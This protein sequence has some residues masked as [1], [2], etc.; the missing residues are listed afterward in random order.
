VAPPQRARGS[1]PEEPRCAC[2]GR[3]ARVRPS[4]LNATATSSHLIS[5]LVCPLAAVARPTAVPKRHRTFSD[6][7]PHPKR[8]ENRLKMIAKT[9][10]DRLQCD[11][12]KPDGRFAKTTREPAHP[13]VGLDGAENEGRRHKALARKAE[14]PRGE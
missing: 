9:L 13:Y 7:G 14:N 2:V 6:S 5:Q 8:V 4:Q 11:F 1:T 10:T 3:R 12:A